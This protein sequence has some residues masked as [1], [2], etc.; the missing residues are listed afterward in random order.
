MYC[1]RPHI[2]TVPVLQAV[3][4]SVSAQYML[5]CLLLYICCQ[6]C[7]VVSLWWCLFLQTSPSNLD[8]LEYQTSTHSI[9][10]F[11]VL[12]LIPDIH[13]Q[14]CVFLGV[15]VNTRHPPT[16]LCVFGCWCWYQTSTH[17]IVCFWVLV[18]IPDIHPQHCVFLGVG[19]N[20][21]H[22]PTALCVFGCWC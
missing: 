20:T 7:D 22:P 19:V 13:P 8:V 4:N 21:R 6:C 3:P 2:D 17:S 14:H 1:F 15:G 9:V 12:V 16:A 5:T 11:W 18:L 10:C